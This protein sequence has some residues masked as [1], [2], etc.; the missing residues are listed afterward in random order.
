[1]AEYIQS[2]VQVVDV[3]DT[4]IFDYDTRKF[5]SKD[6]TILRVASQIVLRHLK[7]CPLFY[8]NFDGKNGNVDFMYGISTVMES[9]AHDAGDDEFEI[10]FAK[11]MQESREE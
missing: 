5:S 4:V 9:I 10:E 2:D 7:E 6:E 8:G 11:N 1:M 3:G